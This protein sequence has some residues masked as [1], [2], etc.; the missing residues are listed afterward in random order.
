M[1]ISCISAKGQQ[2]HSDQKIWR[3]YIQE[4]KACR[5]T[6]EKVI[7]KSNTIGGKF[8]SHPEHTCHADGSSSVRNSLCLTDKTKGNTSGKH[9]LSEWVFLLLLTSY[10]GESLDDSSEGRKQWKKYVGETNDIKVTFRSL[11]DSH[12]HADGNMN[13]SKFIG[14]TLSNNFDI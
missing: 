6:D 10:V 14:V 12:P 7:S 1:S 9:V 8:S 3:M 2:C 5:P 11:N 4:D 13:R